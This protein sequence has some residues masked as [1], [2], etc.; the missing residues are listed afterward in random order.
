MTV[1]ERLCLKE[2]HQFNNLRPHR[3]ACPA[4]VGH[5]QVVLELR[6]LVSRNRDIAKRA[7]SGRDAVDRLAHIFHLAVQV[8]AAFLYCGDRSFTKLQFF[9]LLQNCLEF[10]KT[11][12]FLGNNVC[13]LLF[14]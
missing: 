10:F 7:E 6:Q 5:H 11:K 8:P 4:G 14:I 13:H 12:M 2:Q 9:V 1:G 3:L